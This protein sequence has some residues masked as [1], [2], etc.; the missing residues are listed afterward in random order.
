MRRSFNGTPYERSPSTPKQR[1]SRNPA[2]PSA[3]ILKTLFS[4]AKWFSNKAETSLANRNEDNDEDEGSESD[5]TDSQENS[6][7]ASSFDHV[8]NPAQSEHRIYPQLPQTPAAT[9]G[10]EKTKSPS[11]SPNA[12]LASFFAARGDEPLSEIE[13]EGVIALL[14]KQ[15][16]SATTTEVIP[17]SF[18]TPSRR[19]YTPIFTPV[20]SDSPK[21]AATEIKRIRRPGYLHAMSIASPFRHRASARP[22]G[23]V[24]RSSAPSTPTKYE[25]NSTIAVT[26]TIKETGK[27]NLDELAVP[28][29][30]RARNQDSKQSISETVQKTTGSMTAASM[31]EILDA[32]STVPLQERPVTSPE[33]LKVMLNPYAPSSERKTTA[34]R[35]RS[36]SARKQQRS[37]LDEIR[38]D[39]AISRRISYQPKKSSGLSQSFSITDDVSLFSPKRKI[40]SPEK[41]NTQVQEHKRNGGRAFASHTSEAE[42]KESPS[43]HKSVTSS[44]SRNRGGLFSTIP[45][46]NVHSTTPVFSFAASS[47]SL[48]AESSKGDTRGLNHDDKYGAP[49]GMDIQETDAT[50]TQETRRD[51]SLPPKRG[52]ELHQDDNDADHAEH[53]GF[54]ATISPS[55]TTNLQSSASIG[56]KVDSISE[57]KA[58]GGFE[59]QISDSTSAFRAPIVFNH[60]TSATV[61]GSSNKVDSDVVIHQLRDG[62]EYISPNKSRHKSVEPTEKPTID[63]VINSAQAP[64]VPA[65][66]F[67]FTPGHTKSSSSFTFTTVKDSQPPAPVSGGFSFDAN[68]KVDIV[69]KTIGASRAESSARATGTDQSKSEQFRQPTSSKDA[70]LALSEHDLK[71]YD[72]SI[73]PVSQSDGLKKD[74]LAA[75]VIL[76]HFTVP[77][78][79]APAT[80]S[81]NW[82]MAGMKKPEVGWTCDTCMVS[83]NKDAKICVSCETE[84]LD[85]TSPSSGGPTSSHPAATVASSSGG[86]NWAAA[87]L[88]KPSDQWTCSVC[89]VQN[90]QD[91]TKCLSCESDR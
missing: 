60:A 11:G 56:E 52:L 14:S 2:T 43:N 85:T 67:V 71:A 81:F 15:K 8:A 21:T 13:K 54:T 49:N 64:S 26:D 90:P 33:Q 53:G 19:V 74:V 77:K 55:S 22:S 91:K 7:D 50:E 86:F 4:P 87:G 28:A 51:S 12:L 30:K 29:A 25:L 35:A 6:A 17:P 23:S 47:T 62:T 39:E 9:N 20:K 31:L 61:H 48:Q 76:F 37:A 82:A 70:V 79:E 24:P 32:D 72:F 69:G 83:N 44:T 1:S 45:N 18:V 34:P 10:Q 38:R 65:T 41:A 80:N 66:G 42:A 59:P 89:M 16:E 40:Q 68:K 84:R 88:A 36:S 27:R 58:H 5:S 3:S 46:R 57:H 73:V 63:Q 78:V 75:E